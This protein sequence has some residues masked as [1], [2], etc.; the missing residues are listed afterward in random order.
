VDTA[1]QVER[2]KRRYKVK[3]AKEAVE[4]KEEKK[5]EE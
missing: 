2:F 3:A 1:G 5:A 4:A